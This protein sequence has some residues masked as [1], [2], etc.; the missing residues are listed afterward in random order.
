VLE[1][2]A[3]VWAA[4]E[5]ARR[6]PPPAS[7]FARGHAGPLVALAALTLFNGL[8]GGPAWGVE[9]LLA[10]F[11]FVALA[12][13]F[14]AYFR[15]SGNDTRAIEAALATSLALVTGVGLA[16][17]LGVTRALA[18]EPLFGLA[19]GDGRSATF[20]NANMAAQ[21][22]GFAAAFLVAAG[23]ARSRR[24]T[25][26]RGVARDMLIAAGLGYM[27]L[28]GGRSALVAVAAA[29]ATVATLGG[30]AGRRAVLRPVL[31]AALL[32]VPAA[33]MA[34]W[35][36]TGT[37]RLLEGLDHPPKAESLRI[38][39]RLWQRSVE[40]IGDRPLGAGSGNYLHAFLPYQL[41]DDRLRSEAVVYSSP[42]SEPLRALA[43]EGLAWCALAG[44]LLARL[45]AAAA[46]RARAGSGSAPALVLA[47]GTAFLAVESAFQFPFGM[48]AGA[49]GAAALLGLAVSFVDGGGTVSPPERRRA[50]IAR[51]A[52]VGSLVLATV[53]LGRLV[54]SEYLAATAGPRGGLLRRACDLNPRH[55]RACLGAAW[56]EAR[57]ARR[58]RARVRLAGILDRSP[59]YH[60]A[61]KL[62][63]D[64]SL[65]R[66]DASAG[67]F[68]LWV[69]D[70]LFAERSSQ[71]ERL[72]TR[73]EPGLLDVF[74]SNVAVP[75]YD[76][77]PLAVPAGRSP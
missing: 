61:I 2:L 74:R 25:R 54:A 69:Y 65:A 8:R 67:C 50:S 39:I 77:F 37:P 38:R 47:A 45:V 21:F 16:Q 13:G 66:G 27:V 51:M 35:S 28:L 41:R 10:R 22:V 1:L 49:L 14:Y 46:R 29:L 30:A 70:A 5:A 24:V 44:W 11:A 42:H 15:R 55:L 52:A 43:E 7:G 73:C 23:A 76:R 62:L 26:W 3:I 64:E 56:L 68:H 63:A 17:V 36:G 34:T 40:M 32:A 53:A 20:G 59:Y 48:A 19:A 75:G 60:P 57:G 18:L 4:V 6:Q 9:P 71:H 31:L 72:V 12:A 58:Q 33:A